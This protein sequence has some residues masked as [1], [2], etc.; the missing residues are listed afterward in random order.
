MSLQKQ[1][2]AGVVWTFIQQFGQQ[3]VNFGVSIVLAR[4]LMP[5]EFG[6]I[7]MISVFIGIGNALVN[8]GLTQSLIRS[9]E[10]DQED[11]STVFF[12]NLGASIIIYALI[13]VCSPLIADF[14]NQPILIGIIRLYCLSFIISALTAVQQARLTKEMNFKIQTIIGLPSLVIGGVSG[15]ILAYLGYGVW[16]IVWS[17]LIS[18]VAKT[19][20]FWKYSGWS[21][22]IVF[23][24]DK[25]KS[26]F[27]FGYKITLSNLIAKIASN[28]Y[29]IIIGRFFAASQVG[30]YTRAE[31]MKNLP[32]T[33]LSVALNKVTYPL[34]SDIQNDND[35][36]KKVNQKLMKIVVYVIAPV[37]VFS[38]VLAIPIFRFLLTEKWLPA[39]PY[40]R[41]LCVAGILSPIEMYNVNILMVKGRSDLMLKLTIMKNVLLAIGILIGI[42]FGIYGL[43]YAQVA[44]SLISFLMNAHYTNK[45]I[46]YTAIEQLRDLVPIFLLVLITG[47]SIYFIDSYLSSQIDIFRIIIGLGT[48][49]GLYVILSHLFKFSSFTDLRKLVFKK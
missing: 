45:Y 15:I 48:G 34:F 49:I 33:N 2:S 41:I 14:Y 17:Q 31:T 32:V 3:I 46:N 40:F 26:H 21:P 39:V 24:L 37:L 4:L 13:Y 16:S 8:G 7:G 38:A 28:S 18:G 20:Q 1:A 42:Q 47:F 11:Y 29:L 10:L 9:K 44:L 6:L 25:F 22:S 12:Y 36:L 35:R 19:I 43:L 23:S 30:Y 27:K 5:S